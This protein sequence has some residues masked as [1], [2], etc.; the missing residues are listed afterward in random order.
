MSYLEMIPTP[1]AARTSQEITY[2]K[3]NPARVSSDAWMVSVV[4]GKLIASKEHP[5]KQHR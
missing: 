4:C 2:P 1:I 5:Q 3:P